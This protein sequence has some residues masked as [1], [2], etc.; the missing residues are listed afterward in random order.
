[1]ELREASVTDYLHRKESEEFREEK[2]R[3]QFH[4]KTKGKF[5]QKTRR[6]AAFQ[7]EGPPR[8]ETE[9]WRNCHGA[10]KET[11]AIRHN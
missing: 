11:L 10:S 6:R 5:T 9:A 8:T 7:T 1:M 2:Q 3:L 4:L